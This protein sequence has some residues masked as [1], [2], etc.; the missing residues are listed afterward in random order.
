[1]AY[2]VPIIRNNIRLTPFKFYTEFLDDVANFYRQKTDD[3]IS[4]VLFEFGDEDLTAKYS[5]DPIVLPLLLSLIEQLRLFHGEKLDLK[6]YN[7]GSTQNILE[8]LVNC[9]FFHV[10]GDNQNPNYPIGRN[11]LEYKQ[12]H[13]RPFGSKPIRKEHRIHSYSINDDNLRTSLIGYTKEEDKRDYLLSHYTYKA[14]EHFYDLLYEN[15]LT[16]D[17]KNS[18]LDIISELIT[19]AVLYSDSNAYVLMFSDRYKTK[20]SISDNGVGFKATLSNKKENYYYKPFAL[21]DALLKSSNGLSDIHLT[22]QENL[23]VILETLFYSSLKDRKGLFDL[24]TNVVVESLGYLRIHNDNCQIII[25]PSMQDEVIDLMEVRDSIYELHNL[26]QLS[27]LPEETYKHQLLKLSKAMFEKFVLFYKKITEKYQ[28]DIRFSSV[29]FYKIRFRGVH[30]EVEIP[31]L[32]E[33]D[34]I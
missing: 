13:T 26:S 16:A 18:Y 30:I 21:K 25:S 33:N 14:Q 2:S 29:R 11:I 28:E 17:A 24:M 1:M 3:K 32:N 4:F 12:E 9:D 15:P 20:F 8:F 6:L 31:N 19:N 5:I 7:N 34:S 22:F 10:I 23:S 27:I